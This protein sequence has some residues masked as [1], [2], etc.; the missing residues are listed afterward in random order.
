[1]KAHE[2]HQGIRIIVLK[3]V[4]KTNE[5]TPAYRKLCMTTV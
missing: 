5:I 2:T 1:M 3:I 4:L